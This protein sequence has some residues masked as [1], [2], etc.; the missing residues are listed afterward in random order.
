MDN[1]RLKQLHEQRGGGGV[2]NHA[3]LNALWELRDLHRAGRCDTGP[4]GCLKL[5]DNQETLGHNSI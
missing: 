5:K 2:S 4:T 3:I 1:C